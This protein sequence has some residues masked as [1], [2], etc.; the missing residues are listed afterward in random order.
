MGQRH[1]L[2]ILSFPTPVRMNVHNPVSSIES[3]QPCVARI[4]QN[5]LVCLFKQATSR[6]HVCW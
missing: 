6:L 2:S 5:V 4:A 3:S 1:F